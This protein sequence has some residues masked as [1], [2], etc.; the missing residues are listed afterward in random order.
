MFTH[1]PAFDPEGPRRDDV[2]SWC[3]AN[4]IRRDQIY[5]QKSANKYCKECQAQ[6]VEF[7]RRNRGVLTGAR[8]LHDQGGSFKMDREFI[9]A[10]RSQKVIPFPAEQHGELSVLDNKLNAV[11]KQQWRNNRHNGDF[12]WD[13]FLLFVEL[14]RVGQDSIRSWWTFNFL[15]DIPLITLK[16]V[17]DRLKE[18][19]GG[20]PIRQDLA[21]QY[22]KQYSIWLQDHDEVELI[23]EGDLVEE[24]LDDDHS[25]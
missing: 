24:E 25:K 16:A 5:Y 17:D 14:H 9:L 21:D 8:V 23:Y 2:Q 19:S 20:R 4:K 3:D 15:L 13:A 7:E 10:E 1:D 22:D 12:A 11:A 18:V 6:V